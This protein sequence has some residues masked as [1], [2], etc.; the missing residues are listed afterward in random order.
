MLVEW[1]IEKL[2]CFNTAR[3][4][5]CANR[6]LLCL[7]VEE[8]SASS[9]NIT[10]ENFEDLKLV[11]HND[12][13]FFCTTSPEN[14]GKD[15]D[16]W[17]RQRKS[18]W[19]EQI[20]AVNDVFNFSLSLNTKEGPICSIKYN[21]EGSTKN[22]IIEELSRLNLFKD[23][24]YLLSSYWH[25]DKSVLTLLQDALIFDEN[26]KQIFK[27]SAL[28]DRLRMSLNAVQVSHLYEILSDFNNNEKELPSVL[29]DQRL[30]FY[31]KFGV[32]FVVIVD[33]KTVTGG[34]CPV[35]VWHADANI[36]ELTT[37]VAVRWTILTNLGYR[38][39]DEVDLQKNRN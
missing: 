30:D 14:A 34:D 33:D 29:L 22:T 23:D 36:K 31:R 10:A 38:S 6:K 12:Y 35:T 13:S 26:G 1:G 18:W 37:I 25:V 7:T 4:T 9:S 2:N 11:K 19:Y 39:V 20:N 24:W 5:I 3:Q 32:V 17:L 28:C 27:I 16:F 15:L 21:A 8:Y